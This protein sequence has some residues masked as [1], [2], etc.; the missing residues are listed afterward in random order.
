MKGN[1]KRKGEQKMI[2]LLFIICELIK[3]FN[4]FW[5]VLN[6]Y[7]HRKNLTKYISLKSDSLCT[8]LEYDHWKRELQLR[9]NHQK[10]IID[11]TGYF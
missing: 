11:N 3:K 5:F 7:R 9:P 4:F 8:T 10:L 6:V 2:V 1:G